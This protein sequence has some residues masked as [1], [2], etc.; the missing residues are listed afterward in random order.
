MRNEAEN[1]VLI[2]LGAN[3][4]SPR[5]GSP[6]ATCKAVL[7]MMEECEINVQECSRWFHS[8]PKPISDQPRFVNG[9]VKVKTHLDPAALLGVLLGIEADLGRIRGKENEA[10]VIDLD[11][12]AYGSLVM[13]GKSSG[14]EIPHPRIQERAFVLF[15]LRDVAPNWRHPVSGRPL[16]RMI[17]ALPLGETAQPQDV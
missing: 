1:T 16:A 5:F 4:E 3:L 13:D 6:V 15:P 17:A 10:R 9:V 8:D 12:L 14:L 2:A 11:L 7:G